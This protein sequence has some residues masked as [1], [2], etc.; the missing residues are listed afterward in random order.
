MSRHQG[1]YNMI[2]H[3][4]Y[5]DDDYEDEDD[6]NQQEDDEQYGD[7]NFTRSELE[8]INN[9]SDIFQL[10]FTRKQII[11]ALYETDG[12]SDA[13][14]EYLSN[15]IKK[16]QKQQQPQ[17][18]QATKKQQQLIQA[19]KKEE[20]PQ[21]L[22]QLVKQS[23]SIDKSKNQFHIEYKVDEY[24]S[25]YPSIKYK[26]VIQTNPSTSIVIL[27]HVDTGK[28]T[29]TGK[30]LQIFK[31]LDD[32]EIRKNQK[33][34]KNLGKDSSALAYATDMTKEE[35]EKGVTMDMAYKTIVIGGR[36][37]NLLDSPGHQDFAPHLI[38]G[39]AQADYAILVIDTTKNAFENSIK[40][41]MLREKLQLISAMLIKQ[42][43]VA[44]NKMD[45]IDWNQKQF[46]E[47]KEYIKVSA[48][49]L[50]YNQK[51]IKFIPISAFQGLNIQNKHNIQWYQG[52]TLVQEILNLPP[53]Q[54]G[55]DKP[56]RF[57]ILNRFHQNDGKL[58]GT[59]LLG[60]LH[61]GQLE[62]NINYVILPQGIFCEVKE[63]ERQS[64]EGDIVEIKV[65]TLI[66]SEFQNIQIGSVL[67]QIEYHV[68]VANRL[69]CQISTLD[70]QTPI[71]KGSQYLMHLGAQKIGVV[72]KKLNHIY[73]QDA[74]TIK[75]KFPRAIVS[76]ELAEVELECDGQICVETHINL[77]QL[78]RIILREKFNIVAIGKVTIINVNLNKLKQGKII[79]EQ[80]I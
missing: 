34:A 12:D 14:F 37:Y 15:K 30:L 53:I 44:L 41:G 79:H 67:S 3:G 45:Q 28:S 29:L 66:D 74:Q 33:E 38:A 72:I 16:T 57:T 56:L 31:A 1:V 8:V 49:K 22:P 51:Q 46:E 25:P 42:I 50:G 55:D 4:A 21:Q 69:V 75:K 76:N 73:D 23:N 43:I 48:A 13:A 40:S 70:L 11:D 39:A 36:Q 19:V 2:K 62:K 5:N 78:S 10:D 65:K 54:R 18:P 52:D 63:V 77:E 61:S 20:L 26:N 27:G 35:K 60:K 47:A 71:I 59:C 9:L 7:H 64:V 68:P 6:Y 32:K 80:Q 24:N 58:R 17:K